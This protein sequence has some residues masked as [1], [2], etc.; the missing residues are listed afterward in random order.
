MSN[1]TSEYYIVLK[2]YNCGIVG[3]VDEAGTFKPYNNLTRAEAAVI[4]TRLAYS[5]T[6]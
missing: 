6:R 5:S 4:L 1:D 2:L 3:G